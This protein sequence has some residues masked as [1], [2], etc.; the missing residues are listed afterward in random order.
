MKEVLSLI[1]AKKFYIYFG[2]CFVLVACLGAL[3]WQLHLLTIGTPETQG[4]V[5]DLV[6][7]DSGDMNE[8]ITTSSSVVDQEITYI[9]VDIG[10]AVQRPGV[11]ALPENSLLADLVQKA[12]GF[13]VDVLDIHLVQKQLNLAQILK[14]GEKYYIPYVGEGWNNGLNSSTT[15]SSSSPNS[16]ATGLISVNNADAATL[17]TLKGIGESRAQAIIDHR[18]Y[19][20]IGDLV[21]K[22]AITQSV[23]NN[24]QEYISI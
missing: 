14:N 12:G 2:V 22:G 18:P 19:T 1:L 21:S 24:I 15:A 4:V 6:V 16:T 13:R 8:G 23:F 17:Q 7:V 3:G 9:A 20:V 5:D 11:Y 10:G